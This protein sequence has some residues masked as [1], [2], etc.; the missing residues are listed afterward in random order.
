[1]Y[2]PLLNLNA[3]GLTGG[4]MSGAFFNKRLSV[5]N[6]TSRCDKSLSIIA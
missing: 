5:Q 3:S 4:S 2:V 1:M 6:I